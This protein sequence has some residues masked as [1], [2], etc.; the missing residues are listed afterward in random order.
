[1]RMPFE[2]LM[3]HVATLSEADAALT[4]GQL[5]ERWGEP[6]HRIMDAIDAVQVMNG[7]RTYISLDAGPGDS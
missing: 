4:M 3:R 5:S 6:P 1:M 2:M 7:E